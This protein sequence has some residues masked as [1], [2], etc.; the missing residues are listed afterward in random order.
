[1]MIRLVPLLFFLV[2]LACG[3]NNNRG[4][5][6]EESSFDSQSFLSQKIEYANEYANA[7]DQL[8]SSDLAS[9]DLAIEVYRRAIPDSAL[10]KTA[11][12]DSMLIN[13]N[14]FISTVIQQFDEESLNGNSELIEK[15]RAQVEDSHVNE[16]KQDLGQHGIILTTVAGEFFLQMKQKHLFDKLRGKLT[17]VSARFLTLKVQ[18]E[19]TPSIEEEGNLGYP[20]DT[21]A[22]RIASWESFIVEN[23]DYLLIHDA[24]I[25]CS[26]YITQFIS[27]TEQNPVFDPETKKIQPAYKEA[28]ERY[29][30]AYPDR[31]ST[32][33]IKRL[34]D[35]AAETDFSYNER[36][37]SFLIDTGGQ[38]E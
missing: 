3:Q 26:D 12:A 36:I 37:D 35:L 13:L 24:E 30:Q 8:N 25:R 31:K 7:I 19:Q 16:F 1:M 17:P 20:L 27:G 18:D 38:T 34:Y 14:D 28:F 21:V 22:A 11:M 10:G 9:I 23:P 6:S 15:L 2:V 5:V 32:V 33:T 4:E 29:I